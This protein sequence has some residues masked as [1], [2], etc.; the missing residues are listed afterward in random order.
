MEELIVEKECRLC[1]ETKPLDNFNKSINGKFGYANECKDC[2]REARKQLNYSRITKGTKLCNKC[3]IEQDVSEFSSDCK[4][5]NGLRSNCKSCSIECVNEYG[6]TFDGFIKLLYND[7]HL[8]K[9][10]MPILN[11]KF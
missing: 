2:K 9:F 1:E 8:L 11:K 10:E 7:L 6:S 4:N 5:S 3:E